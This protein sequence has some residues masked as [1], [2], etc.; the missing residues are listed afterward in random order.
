MATIPF[1]PQI[2]TFPGC[3]ALWEGQSGAVGWADTHEF[4]SLIPSN[5]TL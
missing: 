4:P 3:L 1:R 2:L 5:D